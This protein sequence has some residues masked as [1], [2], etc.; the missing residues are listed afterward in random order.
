MAGR[1]LGDY[2]VVKQIGQG[3]LG[4]VFLAE[5]RF[6]KKP[7]MLKVLPEEL[8][9]DRQFIQRFEL[10]IAALA[11]LEH[12]HIVKIHN[13]SSAQGL[14]FLVSD[15][16]VDDQ[17]E[18]TNLAQYLIARGGTLTEEEILILLEQ[19][20]EALDYAHTK[21]RGDKPLFHGGLKPNNIL[22]SQTNPQLSVKLCDF[23]LTPIVG[24]SA[25]LTRTYRVVAETLG[26]AD[27]AF[28][29][30]SHY[31][32]PP[33]EGCKANSLHQSFLQ[34]Y[35]FLAPEQRTL[36]G[37]KESGPCVDRYAFGVLAY[38]LLMHTLPE[39]FFPF[40]SELSEKPQHNWDGL[41]AGCLARDSEK[42]P[43]SLVEEIVEV[44]EKQATTKDSLTLLDKLRQ[45]KSEGQ[46]VTA[47]ILP[48]IPVAPAKIAAPRES[49]AK[50]QP[51]LRSPQIR[52]PV[53]DPNPAAALEVD[54][55]VKHYVPEQMA[56]E[57]VEAIPTEMIVVEGGN[58]SRGSQDGNR[59]EMPKHEVSIENFALDVHPVTNEQYA[60]FLEFMGG[61][62]DHRNQDL[63]KFKESRIK[64]GAGKLSIESGY[65]K[66]PAT[67][68]TWYGAVAYA[69]WVGKR[70]PTEAEWEIAASNA[71]GVRYPNG[72]E[73]EKSN[74]NFFS[75]DTTKVMSYSPNDFGL[76]D[77]AGNVYEWCS[78]WYGY[79]FYEASAQEP[80]QPRGPVQGVYRVLRGGCWKSLKEDLRCSRRHRNKPGSTNSTY[81]FRCAAAV[82]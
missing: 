29:S 33:I 26:V 67:G 1:V 31:P 61:E 15:C 77:M 48:S 45:K 25:V 57:E 27:Q 5:H 35:A 42:R 19:V 40:P 68:V 80:D 3:A 44:G 56:P 78:D 21:L 58:F 50:V 65:A 71:V 75:S 74:A 13:V 82:Q 7:F 18:T 36:N 23:G 8:A 30:K 9:A 72:D 14:Y 81:G 41:L 6:T 2:E 64:R 4:T 22:I 47:S 10:E 76:Y 73:I 51:V 54:P 52:R 20:A 34:T 12:P 28:P 69:E 38:T 24:E 53:T 63:I 32:N 16:V 60:R 11:A 79:N 62:K 43:K 70:L 66:H 59:D 55:V 37:K 49:V 39:G 17:G 46:L